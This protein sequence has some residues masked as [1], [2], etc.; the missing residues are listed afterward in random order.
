MFLNLCEKLIFVCLTLKKLTDYFRERYN[1]AECL[2]IFARVLVAEEV[3]TNIR[4]C[5]DFHRAK[6]LRTSREDNRIIERM[7]LMLFKSMPP[8]QS[9]VRKLEK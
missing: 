4:D 7:P 5:Q 8:D 9:S 1:I 6:H 3:R 2:L